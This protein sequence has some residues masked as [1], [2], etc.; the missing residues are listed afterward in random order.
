MLLGL[1]LE[2][3]ARSA[4]AA[5]HNYLHPVLANA[6]DLL[7]AHPALPGRLV[8]PPPALARA[9]GLLAPSPTHPVCS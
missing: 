4:S 9:V 1:L 3:A 5:S 6:L 2:R 7:A 8:T